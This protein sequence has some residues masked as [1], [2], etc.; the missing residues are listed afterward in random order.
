MTKAGLESD[1]NP[2]FGLGLKMLGSVMSELAKPDQV[3]QP[4]QIGLELELGLDPLDQ[5]QSPN[6]GLDRLNRTQTRLELDPNLD[7]G[8]GLKAIG[9]TRY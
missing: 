5:A 2:E 3:T 1:P 7:F 6:V 4:N 8:L 9:L